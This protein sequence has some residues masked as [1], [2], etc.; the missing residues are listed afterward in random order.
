DS[1]KLQ[2]AMELGC[3]RALT[4]GVD[5]VVATI[6]D[7]TAGRGADS[8]I[9]TASTAD[10]SPIL[11]AEQITRRRGRIV[12]VGVSDPSLSRTAFWDK[13]LLFTASKSSGPSPDGR[14]NAPRF[15]LEFVVWTEGRRLVEF[16]P[17]LSMGSLD[18][19]PLISYRS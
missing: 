16:I 5:D 12:L 4:I 13:E 3:E 19:K 8:V 7:V 15:P 10:N 17:R 9:L 14:E 2:L 18:G 11:L 1:S 6:T